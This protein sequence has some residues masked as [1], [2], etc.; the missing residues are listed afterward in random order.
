MAGTGKK[1]AYAALIRAGVKR[2]AMDTAACVPMDRVSSICCAKGGQYV[3]DCEACQ[4]F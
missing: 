3:N 2:V 1:R 4:Y